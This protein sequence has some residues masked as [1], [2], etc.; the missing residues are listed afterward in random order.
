MI[1][2][3]CEMER[4]VLIA[5]GDGKELGDFSIFARILKRHLEGT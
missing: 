4:H 2:G 1:G 5:Y 3:E